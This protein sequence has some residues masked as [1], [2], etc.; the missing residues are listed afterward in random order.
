MINGCN[1]NPKRAYLLIILFLLPPYGFGQNAVYVDQVGY[2]PQS[3]KFVFVSLPADSFHLV[4]ASNNAVA[5]R[6]NLAIWRVNDPATGKTVFRGDFSGFQRSGRYLIKTTGAGNS[7]P[8]AIKDS[9][10]FEVYKKSLRGFYFQRCGTA[11]APEFAGVYLHGECHAGDGVFHA[12]AGI[13]GSLPATGGWHDAG[14]YGKYAVNAGIT[15]GTLLAAYEYFPKAFSQDHLGIPESN[16]GIPDLLDEARYELAWLLKMQSA[17]GG[18]Y[19]KLTRELFAGFIMPQFDTAVR[20]VYQISSTATADFAAV[21]ARASRVYKNFDAAFAQTCLA[22]AENAWKYLESHPSIIPPN[23]FRN[24]TGTETGEYGDQQDAD[25]RLWAAAELFAATGKDE[26]QTR[27]A[28]LSAQ[29]GLFRSPMSWQDVQAMAHLTCLR[30]TPGNINAALQA[31]IRAS[32]ID[33]CN[34]AVEKRNASGFQV[35]LEPGEYF[36]GSNSHALNKAILLI[37]GYEETR[38]RDYFNTALD[39]LHYVLGANA[40]RMSFVTGIG[41]ASPQNPH[42][43]PSIADVLPAPV[44]GLLVG[45]PNKNLQDPVLAS[46]F[47]SSTPPA[48]AYIDHR[49]SYASN[50]IAINWNAPLVFVSGYFNGAAALSGVKDSGG[51]IPKALEL[52]QNFPNPFSGETMIRFALRHEQNLKLIISDLLGRHILSRELGVIS[53]GAKSV[54]WDGRDET[55]ALLGSGVYLYHLEGKGRSETKKLLLIK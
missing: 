45:G 8:F 32:L 22:A 31:Q 55:G 23:G 13:S 47:N 34:R 6:N 10:Y 26:Y 43:R 20:Y 39:Q 33:Y 36:W 38:N 40:H 29:L 48:L 5:F 1:F 9:A 54:A 21:M 14:D 24:P 35:L 46:R 52:Y 49:D 28:S 44:P 2:L 42:H 27:Y 11:L 4:D 12:T 19:H 30:S 41:T 17:G 3:A 16:N 53:S 18:V 25:E 37:L 7:V 15:V 50:E 51:F